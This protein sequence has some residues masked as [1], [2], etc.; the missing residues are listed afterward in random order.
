MSDDASARLGRVGL[1]RA[2]FAR[3]AVLA[4]AL[5]CALGGAAL[6]PASA[7]SAAA[8]VVSYP[9]AASTVPGSAFTASGTSDEPFDITVRMN[10]DP[11]DI[12]TIPAGTGT[13]SWECAISGLSGGSQTLRVLQNGVETSVAFLLDGA[14]L[15][16]VFPLDG[17]TVYGPLESAR[18]TGDTGDTV[19]VDVDGSGLCMSGPPPSPGAN[20]SCSGGPV[21]SA[22]TH[23]FS[24][25]QG[26][27]T[28]SGS[29]EL[30]TSLPA[31]AIDGGG[32]LALDADDLAGG[33]AVTG[34]GTYYSEEPVALTV[35]LFAAPYSSGDPVLQ[36]C[37]TTPAS[38]GSW[39]CTFASVPPD[40]SYALGVS[41][42]LASTGAT[43]GPLTALSIDSTA[44]LP[45]APPTP[46]APAAPPAPLAPV[47]A[48]P[49][50][51]TSAP[52]A[53]QLS[54][55]DV[56]PGPISTETPTL[57]RLPEL[58]PL[59]ATPDT[60]A[61]ESVERAVQH[62]GPGWD[63]PT[64]VGSTLRTISETPLNIAALGA[65]GGIALLLLLLVALPSRLLDSTLRS[66]YQRAFGWLDPI[67]ASGS[68]L[69]EAM[70]GSRG[71]R[72]GVTGGALLLSA[73]LL[74]F[75][76]PGYGFNEASLRLTIALVISVAALGLL[77]GWATG[78]LAKRWWAVDWSYMVR[79][80]GLLLL[81]AGVLI[82]RLLGLEPGILLGLW[83]GA[84]LAHDLGAARE[85][86]LVLVTTAMI[87]ALGL[88][89]W[90][91][92]S[93]VTPIAAAHPGFGVLLA[94]EV[95]STL[96]RKSLASF[97]VLLLPLT[98]L[99]GLAVW[100]WSRAVWAVSYFALAV[101][102][103]LVVL[104]LQDDWS[105]MRTPPWVL[106]A[107]FAVFA[108][109]SFAIWARFRGR[110]G[111]DP[112]GPASPVTRAAGAE[113]LRSTR[114]E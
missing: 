100:S 26:A 101:V 61:G 84:S 44:P 76:D 38:D 3:V 92:Y 79:P 72:R 68:R 108:A 43:A 85:G 77:R 13:W 46:A 22:G 93:T 9:T 71:L 15:T 78:S 6:L 112:H 41:Q 49:A 86:R 58:P 45:P 69:R 89:A 73:V 32:S 106:I 52:A 42:S 66:N 1:I 91:G 20:W 64:V 8:P 87:T 21:T 107:I 29:F 67:L 31:P 37:T 33:F 40:G 19:F 27:K 11:T 16:L 39:S 114:L 5:L 2:R 80:G 18:G 94:Q 109:V 70:A 65:A 74:G 14:P 56:A 34:T 36:S 25:S 81:I 55:A 4:V 10:S 30:Q 35:D 23:A 63:Q 53:T 48:P 98:Y 62:P 90:V 28:I 82:T 104:P 57:G 50:A 99:D 24:V 60:A 97:I 110:S 17:G 88:V 111:K 51:D 54:T 59:K 103:A 7:A 96:T 113:E 105:D 95:F 12:C 102:F 47:L 75:T 83:L